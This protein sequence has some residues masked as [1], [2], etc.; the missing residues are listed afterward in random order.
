MPMPDL[1]ERDDCLIAPLNE[2]GELVEEREAVLFRVIYP[3]GRTELR[4]PTKP[5]S[6]AADVAKT[7]LGDMMP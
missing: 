3:D 6:Q 2:R 1:I 5:T 7:I 4:S